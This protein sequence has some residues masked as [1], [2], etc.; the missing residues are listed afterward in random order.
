MEK[1]NKSKIEALDKFV[2]GINFSIVKD[3]EVRNTFVRL[4]P[5]TARRMKEIEEDRKSLFAK[6]IEPFPEDKRIAYDNANQER[7]NLLRKF[8][9]TGT[10][11][12]R[13]AFEE[14]Q[15]AFSKEFAELILAVEEYNRAVNEIMS[16]DTD[17]SVDAIDIVKFMDAMEGQSFDV[18]SATFELLDPIVRFVEADDTAR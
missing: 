13:K 3:K 4:I 9:E 2:K 17:L 1:Y 11:E 8:Q 6:F 18:T 5:Q 15:A 16:E 10:D 14:K 7:L 12:D